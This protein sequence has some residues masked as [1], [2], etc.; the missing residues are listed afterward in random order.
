MKGFDPEIGE[1]S[2][3]AI[4][5]IVHTKNK[6]VV[7]EG[8]RRASPFLAGDFCPLAERGGPIYR[9][10]LTKPS[11][12]EDIYS[13]KEKNEKTERE[14][15]TEVYYLINRIIQRVIIGV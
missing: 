13:V 5:D 7:Q 3:S 12:D 8:E 9:L 11:L 2:Q 1:G 10:L 15:E 6:S 4:I 14:K